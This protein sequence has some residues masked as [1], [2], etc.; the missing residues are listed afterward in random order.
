MENK[1]VIATQMLS[2]CNVS[3]RPKILEV[4]NDKFGKECK[5]FYIQSLEDTDYHM[6]ISGMNILAKLYGKDAIKFI[7]PLKNDSNFWVRRVANKLYKQL[8]D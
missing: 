6:R 3:D 8:N 2:R 1:I 5:I 7:E 4:I